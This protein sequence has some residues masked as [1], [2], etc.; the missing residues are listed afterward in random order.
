MWLIPDI[1]RGA[2]TPCQHAFFS[3]DHD[4]RSEPYSGTTSFF[5][6]VLL[7]PQAGNRLLMSFSLCASW[8]MS[9]FLTMASV[10]QTAGL[11]ASNFFVST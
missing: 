3:S 6:V 2:K 8:A 1:E 9:S 7:Y 10:L 5:A 4:I 11:G